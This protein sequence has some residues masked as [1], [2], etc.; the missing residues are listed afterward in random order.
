MKTAVRLF[1]VIC[2]F[3]GTSAAWLILG[4]IMSS[5]SSSQSAELRG[6]VA[7]LWGTPQAQAGPALTFE[8]SAVRDVDRTETVGNIERRVKER[9]AEL[10]KQEVSVE[11]TRVSA[12]LHL[13]QRL[14]GLMWYSLYDVAF[15]G[16]WSY[17]H[18]EAQAGNLRVRFR[19]PDP[20]G[21]Y[22]GFHL[23]IDDKPQDLRPKDG[24]VEAVIPVSPGQRVSIATQ[25]KSRG[26]DEWRYVPDPGVASLKDFQLAMTTDFAD[27]DF[28]ASTLSPSARER[29]GKGY[30]LSWAFEQVV[31]GHAIG[32]VMPKRIQPGE[33]A[34]ALSFSAPVSLL[35]FFLILLVLARLRGL[36]I[37]P[38]NYLFL[39]AAFFSFHML[40]AYSVDH[41]HIAPAFAIA[42]F[43]SVALV[44]SYLRLVVSPRFAFIEAA[45][46]QSVYL[47]G[48]SL[49]HFWD[50]KTGLT[51]TVLSILT[52]FLLMQL[53]GR[54]RWSIAFDRSY[55]SG[56]HIIAPIPGVGG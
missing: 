51:V 36:D 56:P 54:I 25:Y 50:G 3:L 35:F 46:A 2:I 8:W 49:A 19:F 31:T 11:K 45:A 55:K 14:K 9:V 16:A 20:Q 52:L 33:L 34:A 43:V 41:L 15:H 32:M 44:V 7:E 23:F 22:D 29:D 42:S 40:F 37:H 5:R 1:A 12:D 6:R 47:I 30:K 4:G 13:D 28:P 26:M 27:I 18:K 10:Q 17:T 24:A 21:V 38:V 48:F 39:G 53:T